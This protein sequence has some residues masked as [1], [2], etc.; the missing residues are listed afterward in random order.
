MGDLGGELGGIFLFV[1]GLA[2]VVFITVVL[3]VI[4]YLYFHRT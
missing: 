4:W 2:I 3:L 1:S